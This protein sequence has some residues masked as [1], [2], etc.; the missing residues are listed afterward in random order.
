MSDSFAQDGIHSDSKEFSPQ[1]NWCLVQSAYILSI[2]PVAKLHIINVFQRFDSLPPTPV[3]KYIL[4]RV[5]FMLMI[6]LPFQVWCVL[7][8][9]QASSEILQ[10]RAWWWNLSG[11][12]L[13]AGALSWRF[14]D[15]SVGG[16][17]SFN[18]T[19]GHCPADANRLCPLSLG[20][21]KKKK[22]GLYDP[23]NVFWGVKSLP[24]PLP[25]KPMD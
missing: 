14:W 17:C 4:Y 1:S 5:I 8:I 3:K 21:T 22:N 6:F 16:P 24:T 11:K 15:L 23:P 13:L 18:S 2:T 12:L 19:S 9:R 20:V 25:W 10:L 7:V